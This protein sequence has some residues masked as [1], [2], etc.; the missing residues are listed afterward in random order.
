MDG[1]A[2]HTV[3]A[4]PPPGYLLSTDRRPRRV[5]RDRLMAVA[6]EAGWGLCAPTMDE[7]AV[8]AAIGGFALAVTA[9]RVV[10]ST[11][12]RQRSS[13]EVAAACVARGAM[14]RAAQALTSTAVDGEA[15]VA[16][17]RRLLERDPTLTDAGRATRLEQR[18]GRPWAPDEV[19][20]ADMPDAV[21][22]VTR[23]ARTLGRG[24]PGPSGVTPAMMADAVN[25][26]PVLA[27]CLARL[28]LATRTAGLPACLCGT[29]GIVLQQGGKQRLVTP[30][31]VVTRLLSRARVYWRGG[32][33][34][35]VY[36][37]STARDGAVGLSAAFAAASAA[38][39][40]C[41]EI[42]AIDA[43]DTTPLP[44]VEEGLARLGW[45]REEAA[46]V[47]ASFERRVVNVGGYDV[48]P[49]P[50][51]SVPTGDPLSPLAFV[52][53]MQATL[54]RVVTPDVQVL[55][56]LDNII[57]DAADAGAVARFV[58][59]LRRVSPWRLRVRAATQI[60]PD[61]E[62]V[63]DMG[64]LGAGA[65][66]EAKRA[67]RRRL[68]GESEVSAQVLHAL[69]LHVVHASA[70]F[71]ASIGSIDYAADEAQ[72]RAR[73]AERLGVPEEVVVLPVTMGGLGLTPQA[74]TADA[75]ILR[76]A[77]RLLSASGTLGRLSC[78]AVARADRR[79]AYWD[80]VV[81]AVRRHGGDISPGGRLSVDW[82]AV[83]AAGDAAREDAVR[84]AVAAAPMRA[85]PNTGVGRLSA[86]ACM[87]TTWGP[88]ALLSEEETHIAAQLVTRVGAAGPPRCCALCGAVSRPGHARTCR[89]T[90]GT[91]GD[92]HHALVAELAQ[93]LRSAGIRV[94]TNHGVRRGPEAAE[95]VR[96]DLDIEGVPGLG[97]VEVKTF[98]ARACAK[99]Y[100][101]KCAYLRRGVVAKYGGIAAAAHRPLH[102]LIVSSEGELDSES[103][104]LVRR[105]QGVCDDAPGPSLLAAIGHA[106]VRAETAARA[107]L[108]RPPQ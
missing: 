105:L 83:H 13:A 91:R 61:T 65:A 57:V 94:L 20:E 26:S 10:T 56:Y 103:A 71:D 33:S 44:L 38:G 25:A 89:K 3:G 90:C 5:T 58:E 72:L 28:M 17:A 78:K 55:S 29:V 34:N 49:P 36:D 4:A 84:A 104:S 43:Y 18:T 98:V 75:N 24:G 22:C 63:A 47:V 40:V 87:L 7:Q 45:P 95:A 101:D 107:L 99:S 92:F 76:T 51:F 73:L 19:E 67:V 21:R 42:D 60:T 46:G 52:A 9:P 23:A 68:L 108:Q 64:V 69:S 15:A 1:R 37:V 12:A 6:D 96:P 80:A 74:W 62:V 77:D 102:T 14:T 2:E 82:D 93:R 85:A 16:V 79:G 41:A 53:A 88:R 50:G 100:A 31:D 11:R 54:D 30:P 81:E 27:R 8:Q 70:R 106:V 86:A 97:Y 66:A 35:A 32:W 39:R 48:L 59:A